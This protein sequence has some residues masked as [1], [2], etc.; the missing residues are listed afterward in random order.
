MKKIVLLLLI[1][2]FIKIFGQSPKMEVVVASDENVDGI[3][4][5][6]KSTNSQNTFAIKGINNSL[7]GLATGV[8][9]ETK[10]SGAFGVWG[11]SDNGVGSGGTSQNGVGLYG[12]SED[13]IGLQAF[14]RNGIAAYFSSNNGHALITG[15]GFIGIKTGTP[16]YQMTFKSDL[17]DKISFWG[18]ED[19][20]V[21][22]HYGIGIQAST[23]Q[24][25]VPSIN[26]NLVFGV[27][28]SADF[29]ENFRI[30]GKGN[31]QNKG[32]DAGYRFW[33]RNFVDKSFQWYAN[34]GNAYLYRHHNGA[35][36]VL[37]VL[38]NGNIEI[39]AFTKLGNTIPPGAA[40]G[41]TTPSIKVLKLVGTTGSTE[42]SSVLIKTGFL[43][44]SSIKVLGLQIIVDNQFLPETTTF[45]G[46][47]YAVKLDL[48]DV[49]VVNYPG[50]S[51]NILNKPVR[52][53]LTY[54]E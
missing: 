31:L 13:N 40:A 26:D 30:T 54:E 29:S 9:G 12:G 27:G 52:I 50:Q 10:G 53:L 14:S 48:G 45:T 28:R 47:R 41:A 22:P 38:E 8:Y 49:L 42:G 36:N 15:D 17:G 23:L 2:S 34:N 33:D 35:G 51:A 20:N 1:T 7:S 39:G 37:S 3:V 16:K 25:F 11:K 32:V 5:N 18:G 44:L 24:F 21:S 4:A 19:S 46:V 43:G 6:L